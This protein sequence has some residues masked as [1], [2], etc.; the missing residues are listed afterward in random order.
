MRVLIIEDEIKLA[1]ALQT[2]LQSEGYEAETR[3]DGQTGYKA[4]RDGVFDLILLDINLPLMDG[5]SLCTKL[6]QSGKDIAIIMLTARDTTSDRVLGLDAGADD[7]LVKPFETSE[8]LARI[9]ALLR[10]QT[11]ATTTLAIADLTLDTHAETVKRGNI[12]INL[13]ATEYRLVKFLAERPNQ[14]VTKEELMTNVW[15]MEPNKESNI[16]D[17]YVGYVR[18]KI[19]KAF[20]RSVPLLHTIK[21][22][23]YRLGL[24][25]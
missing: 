20:P 8:L 18:K 13:S 22:R 21:G 14:I 25:A 24:M 19:D 23:G 5:V 11:K 16:V 1:K 6:R 2:I 3:F 17:V 7:Y 9:R 10:R 12:E 4:A 15:Q